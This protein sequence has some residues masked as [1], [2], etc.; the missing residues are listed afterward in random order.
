MS[1]APVWQ[2]TAVAADGTHHVL[3]DRPLYGERFDEVLKFHDPGLAPVRRGAAAWHIRADG[4]AAYVRRFGRTFGFYEGLAAV[5]SGDGWHHI[6]ADGADAYA[7]RHG[8]CGNFQGGRCPVRRPDGRYLH[9]LA[10]G[11]PAYE[12]RWCYAGDYRDGVAVVAREDGR[13]THIDRDGA[14]VHGQW[15]VDLDVFHKGFARAR[16]ERGWTH[17]DA[18]GRPRYARRF[19]SVEPF[20]NG[21]ARVEGFDGEV[22]VI[23]EAGRTRLIARHDL[24]AVEF[25]QGRLGAW[26]VGEEIHRGSHGAVYASGDHAVLKSTSNLSAWSREVMLLE[27]LGGVGAPRLLDAF[28]RAGTGYVVMERVHGAPLGGRNRGP[29]RPLA[30]ALRVIRGLLDTVGRLHAMGWLHTDI[31]PENVLEAGAEVV[32]LDLANAV[33]IDKSGRWSGEV[34]WGRWEFV[35]PEQFEGFRVL[36]ASVDTYAL[37]GLLVYLATGRGPF[38]VDVAG[39]RGRGWA[40]VREAFLAA[41]ASPALAA[42]PEALRPVLGQGLDPEPGRRFPSID[43]L[44]AALGVDHA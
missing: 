2:R 9:I 17:V 43:A 39:L 23:D 36:D 1:L 7:A 22:E 34:H 27:A 14:V 3:G 25:R 8:W 26:Q 42:I 29:A 44:R 33:R 20:Y 19:A 16:D 15:F 32:L 38:P 41:R 11:R 21:Q 5:E 35:P 6:L 12:R 13:S 4:G 40:T 31:H 37:V 28:T 18:A 30:A 10:D 24:P